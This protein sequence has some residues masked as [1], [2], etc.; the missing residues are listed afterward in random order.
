MLLQ[1][2]GM[3]M[4]ELEAVLSCLICTN[5]MCEPTTM[6]CGHSFCR[7][8]TIKWCYKYRHYSCPICRQK[9]DNS[10]PN[11]NLTLKALI[12]C[13]QQMSNK[14]KQCLNEL[15]NKSDLK[16]HTKLDEKKYK[17]SNGHALPI[18]DHDKLMKRVTYSLRANHTQQ[19]STERKYEYIDDINGPNDSYAELTANCNDST[20]KRINFFK[21]PFNIFFTF[22]GLCLLLSIK[23]FKSFFK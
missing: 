1:N 7:S 11:V 10:L 3:T 21:Y 20:L 16:N 12:E 6:H 19:G 15:I 4:N 18:L 22:F 8:C 5:S 17:M 14:K 9:V 2:S 23:L 13:V